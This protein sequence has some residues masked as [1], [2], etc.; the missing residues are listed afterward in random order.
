MPGDRHTLP[1]SGTAPTPALSI[2]A[3]LVMLALLAI[4]PLL[5]D[6][7]RLVEAERTERVAVAAREAL[8]IAR[9]DI[10]SQQEGLAAARA[11]LQVAA[12][13]YVAMGAR[14]D[15]CDSLLAALVAGVRWIRTLSVARPDGRIM[16]STAPRA[17]GINLADQSYFQG[18]Q[19]S[20]DW[21]LSDYMVARRPRAPILMAA[22][23]VPAGGEFAGGVLV[24]GLDPQWIGRLETAVGGQRDAVALMVDGEGRI[25]ASHPRVDDWIGSPV[26]DAALLAALSAQS[27]GTLTTSGL[28][29]VARV[30]GF[31][32]VPGTSARIIIGLAETE[33]LGRIER[34]RRI[35]Y[36]Q[37]ALVGILVLF[38]VW[39]AGEHLI[40]RPIGALARS[41]GQI[42]EGDLDLRLASRA[43]AGEFAP[44][45]HALDAMARRL[46]AREEEL[47]VANT[48]LE[49]LSKIDG[50]TSLANR[51]GFDVELEAQ[52]ERS[53]PLAQP[54]ALLMIDVDHFKLFNDHYGHVEGDDCLRRI[55]EVI[56]AAALE[57]SYLAARYGGEEF[58]LLL[59]ATDRHAAVTAAARLRRAVEDL[60]IAHV[61]TPCGRVTVS[62]GVAARAPRTQASAQ[63]LIEAADRALYAAKRQGR[64]AVVADV[65]IDDLV[66]G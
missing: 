24:A 34:E 19:R 48:H 44:L 31:L 2:R 38:G 61:M 58:A 5:V 25:I 41:A 66:A 7:I 10:E 11:M 16:C 33:V 17:T 52:W 45:A 57:G 47:R 4:A 53:A 8:E 54:L 15:G 32:Q 56:A 6:R 35:A 64:N 30:F 1:Q 59:P 18:V 13:S 37:L 49:A 46:G 50:L 12:R 42:G 65:E 20:G 3:R 14:P 23:P 9:R 39:Y 27:A 28:D 63:G 62:I 55:G 40:V 36:G 21:T 26:P 51:R 60:G 43:W 22:L 29:D